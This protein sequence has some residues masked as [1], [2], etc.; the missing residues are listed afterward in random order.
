MSPTEWIGASQVMRSR[1]GSSAASASGVGQVGILE[2][3]LRERLGDPAVEAGVGVDVDRRA[4]VGALEVDRGDRAGVDE[5]LDQLVRPVRRAVELEAQPRVGLEPAAD[6]LEARRAAEPQGDDERDR[7]RLAL[8]HVGER[9]AGLAEREVE[10]GA[11]DRPAAVEVEGGEEGRRVRE[12]VELADVAGEAVERPLAGE[13]ERLLAGLQLGVLL[14]VVGDVLAETLLAEPA[15]VEGGRDP[16]AELRPRSCAGAPRGE[17]LD[18]QGQLG[19][20]LVR[21]HDLTRH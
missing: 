3:G 17:V 2:P 4:L 13:R 19:D 9:A 20:A 1:W 11:L 5:L 16:V 15:Q 6:G 18:G 21:G 10:R 12:Q 7:A 8:E 14:G